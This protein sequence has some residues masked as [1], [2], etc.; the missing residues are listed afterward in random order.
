MLQQHWLKSLDM[1][2]YRPKSYAA[3]VSPSEAMHKIT[4]SLAQWKGSKKASSQV[5]PLKPYFNTNYYIVLYM[6]LNF[7]YLF[8]NKI[9]HLHVRKL[10][11]HFAKGLVSVYNVNNSTTCLLYRSIHFLSEST[12]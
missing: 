1:F 12:S 8:D 3:P 5:S 9:L 6:P 7:M 2:Y 4:T 11:L 10:P